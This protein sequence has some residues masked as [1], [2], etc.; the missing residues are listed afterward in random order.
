[1]KKKV[2]FNIWL[3]NGPNF[4]Y[5]LFF[6]NIIRHRQ[7]LKSLKKSFGRRQSFSFFKDEIK[8]SHKRLYSMELNLNNCNL[9]LKFFMDVTCNK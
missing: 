4:I 3:S 6:K 8:I 1:M 5:I 2:L 7:R 9:I